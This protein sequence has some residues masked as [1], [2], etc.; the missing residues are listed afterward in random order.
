MTSELQEIRRSVCAKAK[1]TN[2]SITA[3]LLTK[4]VSY[5]SIVAHPDGYVDYSKLEGIDFDLI[6]KPFGV[7]GI[8][9]SLREFAIN[10]LNQHHGI[11]AIERF[12]WE[13][14]GTR[15]FDADGVSKE[16]S[17][18]Q[19]TAISLFQASLPPPIVAL[20][21]DLQGSCEVKCVGR[22]SLGWWD[23]RAV[24]GQR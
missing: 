24:I 18:G 4:E 15:D 10:A 14:T 5:G 22:S 2:Q 13:R 21:K 19:V 16:F 8:V 3:A 17:I 1:L 12:G 9:I 7:K 6:V 11:Q 23:V 20:S